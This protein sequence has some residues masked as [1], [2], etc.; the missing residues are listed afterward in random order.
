MT[1]L[2]WLLPTFLPMVAPCSLGSPAAMGVLAG[3][4]CQLPRLHR[5][6]GRV[7]SPCIPKI[8]ANACVNV[9]IQPATPVSTPASASARRQGWRSTGERVQ[10]IRL[11]RPVVF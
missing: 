5:G 8:D 11:Q 2:S 6:V 4:R 1:T 9:A 3:V 7:Q 10:E